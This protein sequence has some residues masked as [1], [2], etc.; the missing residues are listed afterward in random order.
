MAGQFLV[1]H[2]LVGLCEGDGAGIT[3]V[4]S[5]CGLD[6]SLLAYGDN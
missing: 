3:A 5:A 1:K 2:W 4:L 6:S